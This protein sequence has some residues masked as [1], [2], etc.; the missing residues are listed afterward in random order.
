MIQRRRLKASRNIGLLA[1]DSA[2][3]LEV[4]GASFAAFFHHAGMRPHRTR[5]NSRSAP[6][7]ITASMLSVGAML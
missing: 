3:A 1:I 4:D 2:R 5:A 6:S 7:G